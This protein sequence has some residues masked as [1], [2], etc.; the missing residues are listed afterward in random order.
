[1]PPQFIVL[2]HTGAWPALG[3]L[4]TDVRSDVSCHRY[5]QPGIKICK[6]VPDDCIA[7]CAG[8]ADV[9]PWSDAFGAN[10][11]TVSLHIE[12][13]YDPNKDTSWNRGVILSGA[14]QCVEWIGRYGLLPIV[15]H[16]QVDRRKDDP[17][18]FP[19][20]TFDYMVA[21]GIGLGMDNRL[22][23]WKQMAS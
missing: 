9:G 1:M 18:H 15:Y 11:N 2:H 14:C 13:C 10:F 16:S 19:R 23:E 5:V 3:W 21:R 12:M 6:V 7:Y 20:G 17:A 8:F 4:T 22:I